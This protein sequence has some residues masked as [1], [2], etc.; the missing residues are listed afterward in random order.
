MN[1]AIIKRSILI[2]GRK[3]SISL[4]DMFWHALKDIAAEQ[5]VSTPSLLTEI[6]RKRGET[7]F[8]SA[9]RQFVMAY[10]IGLVSEYRDAATQS[11][12]PPARDSHNGATARSPASTTVS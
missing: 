12:E 4:E 6:D 5:R 10:Y 7:N 2:M 3:T 8:S 9:V 1:S 11:V